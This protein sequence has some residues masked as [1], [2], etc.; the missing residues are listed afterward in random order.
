MTHATSLSTHT[1]LSYGSRGVQGL[2]F[3]FEFRRI[4]SKVFETSSHQSHRTTLKLRR[5]LLQF[6]TNSGCTILSWFYL[7][8]SGPTSS[9]VGSLEVYMSYLQVI[10]HRP[11]IQSI[12][13]SRIVF[14][15]SYQP[16]LAVVVL[17]L[18]AGQSCSDF[19][20]SAQ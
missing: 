20:A 9:D 12:A 19:L 10:A 14:P 1:I 2:F 13:R 18:K 5:H 4:T 7:R 16:L 11:P 6:I 8:E 3:F 17:K 15:S